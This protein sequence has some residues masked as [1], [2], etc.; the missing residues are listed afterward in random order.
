MSQADEASFDIGRMVR[1]GWLL[2]GAGAAVELLVFR[3]LWGAI[4]LTAAGGVAII[5][6]RWLEAVLGRVLQPGRP[7]FDGGSV[8]RILARMALLGALFAVLV[9]VPEV[10][11]VAIAV[12]FTAAIVAVL[13]EGVRWARSGGG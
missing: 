2:V 12:G 11:P 6:T 1:L 7:R 10:D 3:S 9:W 4:S 5:N 8:L 13:A